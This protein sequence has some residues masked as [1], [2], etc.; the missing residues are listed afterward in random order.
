[1]QFLAPEEFN[2]LCYEVF[3]TPQG[4]KLLQQLMY[5]ALSP[6]PTGLRADYG[7]AF[8]FGRKTFMDQILEA[9]ERHNE[10]LNKKDGVI[11]NERRTEY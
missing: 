7:P 10:V 11:L 1:M 2:S 3:T 4:T 9:L 8:E 5:K 6:H